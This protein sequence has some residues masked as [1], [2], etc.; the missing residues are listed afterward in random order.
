M[1]RF[2]LLPAV[3][4]VLM[5]LAAA[6][7]SSPTGYTESGPTWSSPYGYSDKRI[8]PDEYSVVVI[9]N[10]ATS[11][12]RAAEIALLRASDLTLERGRTHFTVLH[13]L[14]EKRDAEVLITLPAAPYAVVPVA[15]SATKE[16]TAI[17]VF[18]LLP[19]GEE[20]PREAVDAAR[21]VQRLGES[22]GRD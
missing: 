14:S 19:A 21:I 18:R 11:R 2:R 3:P 15:S 4:A 9:G 22:L 5:L 8:G 16:P 20:S 7:C 1:I 17:L 12:E 6:G 10:P 13:R